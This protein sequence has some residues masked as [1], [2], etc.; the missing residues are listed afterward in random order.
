MPCPCCK[1]PTTVCG[2]IAS[3]VVICGIIWLVIEVVK[4]I[5]LPTLI[6]VGVVLG[7]VV[8]YKYFTE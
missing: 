1:P 6:M 8:F 4:V 7:S 5:W 3:A 2:A